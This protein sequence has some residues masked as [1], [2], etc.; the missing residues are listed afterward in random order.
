MNALGL[1]VALALLGVAWLLVTYW[2]ARS[3]REGDPAP[4]TRDRRKPAIADLTEPAITDLTERAIDDLTN[5]ARPR[6][7]KPRGPVNRHG[8]G[9]THLTG[10]G[11][12]W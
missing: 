5:R 1:P 7:P 12:T 6:F 8:C 9:T 4:A 10:N 11:V 2:L 3:T